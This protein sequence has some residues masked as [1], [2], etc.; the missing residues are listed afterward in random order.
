MYF[1][2]LR[3]TLDRNRV[4]KVLRKRR[5]ALQC[6]I[7]FEYNIRCIFQRVETDAHGEIGR[8]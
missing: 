7:S 8:D 2:E 4:S 3:S 1:M 6:D 5:D